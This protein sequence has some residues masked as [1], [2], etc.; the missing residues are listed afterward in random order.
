MRVGGGGGS[1][2]EEMSEEGTIQWSP[3][4]IDPRYL[5]QGILRAG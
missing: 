2:A 3:L 5:Y 1:G 4:S